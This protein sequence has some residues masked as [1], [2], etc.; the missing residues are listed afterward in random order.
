MTT[1]ARQPRGTLNPTVYRSVDGFTVQ[2][3]VVTDAQLQFVGLLWCV[4][5]E[6]G[7]DLRGIRADIEITNAEMN[8]NTVYEYEYWDKNESPKNSSVLFFFIYT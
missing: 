4:W 8:T 2:V 1:I 3:N 6:Y 5:I 7:V